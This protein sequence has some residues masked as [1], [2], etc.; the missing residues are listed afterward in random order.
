MPITAEWDDTQGFW[1]ITSAELL[2]L[3]EL[4]EKTDWRHGSDVL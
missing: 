1:M 2:R 3:D 4:I